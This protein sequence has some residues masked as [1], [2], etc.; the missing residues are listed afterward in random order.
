MLA[1]GHAVHRVFFYHDGVNNGTRLATP[2][3][4]ERDVTARWSTLAAEHALDLVICVAAAQRRG[5]VDDDEAR[6][7]GKGRDQHR[8]GLSHL[9]PR[10]AGRHGDRVRPARGVRLSPVSVPARKRILFL[11]RRAPHGTIHAQEGLEVVLISAAFEQRVSLAFMDDGVYQLKREQDPGP[12]GMKDFSRTFRALD[13]FEVEALYV[14]RESLEARGL[15][16]SDL[17]TAVRVVDAAALGAI[18]E[19]QDVVLGL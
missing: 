11:N 8:R 12:L 13:D 15:D 6:R 9:G 5:I 7:Q 17:V 3:Q 2:P 1:K 14:E 16:A 19:S 18:L 10:P 4:D